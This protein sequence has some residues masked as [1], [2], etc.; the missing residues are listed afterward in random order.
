MSLISNLP[1]WSHAPI[2]KFVAREPI[3]GTQQTPFSKEA[4]QEV[5]QGVAAVAFLSAMDEVEGSDQAMGQPGVVVQDNVT[6]HFEGNPKVPGG[7]MKAVM[8][9]VDAE[10]GAELAY[11][12]NNDSQELSVLAVAKAGD[13]TLVNG[14]VVS[15]GQNGE[16][17]GYIIAGA[18]A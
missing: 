6:L 11:Y 3:E 7:D 10:K 8:H 2:N 17:Q 15:P 9:A 13:M 1:Q 4:F 16:M 14:A 5:G 12:V 18:V